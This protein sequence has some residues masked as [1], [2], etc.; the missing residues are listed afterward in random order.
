MSRT[1]YQSLKHKE[2]KSW[3]RVSVA[4][5]YFLQ[6][7]VFASWASRI[8]D[9][10]NTLGMNDARL[11]A[12]LFLIPVGQLSAMALSGYLV[13]RF[14]SRLMLLIGAV[15]YAVALVLLGVAGT[16]MQ[17]SAALVFFGMAAN[18]CN[19]SV[20]T[21]AV[22]V[23]R[24]YGRSIMASFH[25]LWSLAGFAGGI[26]STLMVAVDVPPLIHFCIILGAALVVISA[27]GGSILPRDRMRNTDKEAGKK[28]IFTKPDKLVVILGVIAFGSMVCEGTMFDWSGVYFEQV[29]EAPK[30]FIRLGY[31]ASMCSMAVG[32]FAADRF[33]IR[34]GVVNILRFSG[35]TIAVGLL[36]SVLFPQIP[37]A[38]AGFLL[39]GLG[40]SSIVPICYS[41]AGK[42]SSMLP[43]VAIA[44]VST[45]GFLGFLLGPPV[46]G[47]VSHALNLRWSL[48]L[49][50]LVGIAIAVLAPFVK[51]KTK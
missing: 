10:K 38:T 3:Y 49:I 12:V 18:L 41:L 19:I 4:A 29:V 34:F 23:E 24:L 32:R 30:N 6:G 26:I 39:I 9:I 5:F 42:S 2:P 7:L 44:M 27:M 50:T 14:G 1:L 46:I 40:V 48:G 28:K 47:F 35:V 21:Q 33:I 22:G 13:S 43:G 25:G 11:G 45:I 51:T 36:L 16:V 15:W 8:P 31:I 37:M 17:L 20:N